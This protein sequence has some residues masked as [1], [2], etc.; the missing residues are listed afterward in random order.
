MLSEI[1]TWRLFK[2]TEV[3]EVNNQLITLITN[4]KRKSLLDFLDLSRTK[5]LTVSEQ[6]HTKTRGNEIIRQQN[7]R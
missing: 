4:K 5:V 7:K 6:S 1:H 2:G 3:S